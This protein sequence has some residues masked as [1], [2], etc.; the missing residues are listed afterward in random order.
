MWEVWHF[1]FYLHGHLFAGDPVK[2][3]RRIPPRGPVRRSV[4]S[5]PQPAPLPR[6]PALPQCCPSQ[7][8][9]SGPRLHSELVWATQEETRCTALH[10]YHTLMIS[11]ILLSFLS[12]STMSI[13]SN[14]DRLLL[15]T[16][17]WNCARAWLAFSSSLQ[18]TEQASHKQN[19]SH[20]RMQ[21]D[22][23]C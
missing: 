21:T 4:P 15:W 10:C 9:A 20:R 3:Q 13:F 16:D 14:D 8:A 5:L 18:E 2:L 23:A 6:G 1:Q 12:F 19:R 7:D 11:V 17:C 22:Y